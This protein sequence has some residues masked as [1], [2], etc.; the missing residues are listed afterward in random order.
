M[1]P[2]APFGFGDA[3]TPQ[4]VI[5]EMQ[6]AG[7]GATRPVIIEQNGVDHV[8]NVVNHGGQVYFVDTQMGM[9]VTLKPN[10]VVKLGNAP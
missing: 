7:S 4:A 10:V 2:S 5:T 3:T 9:I 6:Q 8:I 1:L